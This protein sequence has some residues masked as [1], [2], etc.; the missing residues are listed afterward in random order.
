MVLCCPLLLFH[1]VLPIPLCSSYSTSCQFR[2]RKW[3]KVNPWVLSERISEEFDEHQNWCRSWPT[4]IWEMSISTAWTMAMVLCGQTSAPCDPHPAEWLLGKTHHAAPF[5]PTPSEYQASWNQTKTIFSHS[6]SRSLIHL[7]PQPHCS[8]TKWSQ[9]HGTL[10]WNKHTHTNCLCPLRCCLLQTFLSWLYTSDIKII[11]CW[12]F[13]VYAVPGV[14]QSWRMLPQGAPSLGT[15]T[16][17]CTSAASTQL[18]PQNL[19]TA[20]KS[21]WV[22]SALVFGWPLWGR[23]FWTQE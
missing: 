16:G 22:W 13:L 1:L 17:C 4:V 5:R 19:K 20:V 23:I 9:T 7:R 2:K 10:L 15:L 14:W 21:N 12:I 18:K 11:E 3:Q 6:P 8:C